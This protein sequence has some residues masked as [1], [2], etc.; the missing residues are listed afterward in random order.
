MTD[1]EQAIIA[2]RAAADRQVAH[3]NSTLDEVLLPNARELLAEQDAT[4]AWAILSTKLRGELD[5]RPDFL[6]DMVAQLAIRAARD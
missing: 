4:D 3:V 2:A 6:A 1:R 5:D